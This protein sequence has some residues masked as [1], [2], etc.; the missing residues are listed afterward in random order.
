MLSGCSDNCQTS[1][2]LVFSEFLESSFTW[3]SCLSE[4]M[5]KDLLVRVLHPGAGK[6]AG[7]EPRLGEV[8]YCWSLEVCMCA[9]VC[10]R[11]YAYVCVSRGAHRCVSMGACVCVS[12]GACVCKHARA[13]M[14]VQACVMGGR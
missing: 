9:P 11:V 12:M 2:I 3:P 1:F 10:R 7:Q 5:V 6:G 4:E 8:W 14:R 13:C